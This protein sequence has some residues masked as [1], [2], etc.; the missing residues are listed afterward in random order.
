MGCETRRRSA[1]EDEGAG[2]SVDAG[3]GMAAVAVGDAEI[4]ALRHQILFVQRQ[5]ARPLFEEADATIRL[6]WPH[7]WTAVVGGAPLWS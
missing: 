7:L 2:C 6:L 1:V 5:A 3:D 4:L